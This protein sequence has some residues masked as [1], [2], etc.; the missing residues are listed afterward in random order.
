MPA[1]LRACRSNSRRW[2]RCLLSA[3]NSLS[4][5]SCRPV[6][7]LGAMGLIVNGDSAPLDSISNRD[8]EGSDKPSDYDPGRR[9]TEHDVVGHRNPSELR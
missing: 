9:Q 4:L 2:M 5:Q 3:V 8:P 1:C 7:P 6:H